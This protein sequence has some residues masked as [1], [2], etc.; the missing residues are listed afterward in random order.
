MLW[1]GLS[2]LTRNLSSE[3]VGAHSNKRRV[4]SSHSGVGNSMAKGSIGGSNSSKGVSSISKTI[5]VAISSI[6]KSR[7]SLGFSF[8]LP[9]LLSAGNSSTKIVGADSYIGG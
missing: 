7:V 5:G 8:S 9:L 3:V 1:T 2:P 6:Q 4:D